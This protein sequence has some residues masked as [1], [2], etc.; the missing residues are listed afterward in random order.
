M[1]DVKRMVI[2]VFVAGFLA[3]GTMV[4]QTQTLEGTV[5]DAMCG[6]QHKG[7]NAAGC[8][9][10]CVGGGSNYAL[11]VGDKVYQL[12]GMEDQLAKIGPAKAKVTGKVDGMKIQVTSVTPA[13]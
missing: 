2:A 5:S 8:L 12:S 4:A 11:V 9:K 7:G 13:S 10:G 1:V 6:M 3:V